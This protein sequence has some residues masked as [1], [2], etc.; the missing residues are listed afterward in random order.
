MRNS[1]RWC[2]LRGW[3]IN[4][5]LRR[6]SEC[7]SNWCL[8]KGRA[9]TSLLSK[10][11]SNQNRLTANVTCETRLNQKL[12]TSTERSWWTRGQGAR[13]QNYKQQS[14][15]WQLG[16]YEAWKLV[17]HTNRQ[18]HTCTARRMQAH[19]HWHTEPNTHA[20]GDA[21]AQQLSVGFQNK[22]INHHYTH[23]H[24]HRTRVGRGLV[25]LRDS[26][27]RH[28]DTSVQPFT[29]AVMAT[30]VKWSKAVCACVRVHEQEL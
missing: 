29:A 17:M 27:K 16:R 14:C 3:E 19:D 9:T 6:G 24:K 18:K 28:T 2:V 26:S 15:Q 12:L 20:H 8:V 23:T 22:G 4:N 5:S 10:T 11:F 21:N 13:C 1:Y 30:K 25:C 7:H